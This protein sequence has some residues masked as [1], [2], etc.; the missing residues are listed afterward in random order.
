MEK[1]YKNIGNQWNLFFFLINVNTARVY[2]V[3]RI[4]DFTNKKYRFGQFKKKIK[5][6]NIEI[7]NYKSYKHEKN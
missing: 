1:N 5:L 2:N 4:L 6:K 7:N 3:K